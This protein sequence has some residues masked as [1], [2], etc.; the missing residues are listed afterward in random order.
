VTLEQLKVLEE[1][2]QQHITSISSG[3]SVM[4][5]QEFEQNPFNS[6]IIPSET[7]SSGLIINN[8]DKVGFEQ[9]PS[10]IFLD[11]TNFS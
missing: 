2:P 8:A 5:D 6:G 11:Q 10:S 4:E 3:M 7:L 1:R 9:G